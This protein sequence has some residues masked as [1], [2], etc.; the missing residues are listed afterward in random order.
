MGRG[1]GIQL[2][3]SHLYFVS[4]ACYLSRW[5]PAS[6]SSRWTPASMSSRWTPASMSSRWTLA[7][8]SFAYHPHQYPSKH[9]TLRP[10][11][12]NVR[13]TSSTLIQHRVNAMYCCVVCSRTDTCP[14]YR[15]LGAK[16][17]Y[18]T[19]VRVADRIL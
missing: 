18:L 5:T 10:C 19:L 1:N 6:M 4:S 13:P 11:R 7:S 12:F 14:L 3:V 17:S 15:R 8:M 16:G 2:Q 9:K